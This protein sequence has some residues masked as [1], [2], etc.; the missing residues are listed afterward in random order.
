[1]YLC[2]YDDVVMIIDF[3][4]VIE[5]LKVKNRSDMNDKNKMQL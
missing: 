3:K 2:L 1:M 4:L 5:S